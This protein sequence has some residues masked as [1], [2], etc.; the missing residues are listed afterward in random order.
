MIPITAP[1]GR[2]K[3][4]INHTRGSIAHA[5]ALYCLKGGTT[6][7]ICRPQEVERLAAEI[8]LWAQAMDERLKIVTL[9][10]LPGL[11]KD[12]AEMM[13]QRSDKVME[14]MGALGEL[15]TCLGQQRTHPC[16]SLAIIAD[17]EALTQ[18]MPQSVGGL[19][20][21]VGELIP[22]AALKEKLGMEL[23]YHHEALCESPGQF[24]LR[25]GIVDIYPP[26]ESAP[27]RL[28]FFGETIDQIKHFDPTTQRSLD[29]KLD[30]ISLSS[31]RTDSGEWKSGGFMG[32]L[33]EQ[34]NWIVVEPKE[35]EALHPEAFNI[36]E[37]ISPGAGH[38]A[39]FLNR[40]CDEW[41]GL[42]RL[43]AESGFFKD[44]PCREA[45]VDIPAK[46]RP[47]PAA[48]LVGEERT[49]AE[50]KMLAGFVERVAPMKARTFAFARGET[51]KEFQ[52]IL[53]PL[54]PRYIPGAIG[55]GFIFRGY[56]EGNN[57]HPLY[58][59]AL[60]EG[61][62]NNGAA[63]QTPM[64][65]KSLRTSP[66]QAN[67]MSQSMGGISQPLPFS[68]V[69]ALQAQSAVKLPEQPHCSKSTALDTGDDRDN[70]TLSPVLALSPGDLP[71][72]GSVYT[73]ARASRR[74][75]HRNAVNELLDF[76]QVAEGDYLV[77]LEHGI[78]RYRGMGKLDDGD[79]VLSLE[80]DE[81]LI[82]HLRFS[83]SHLIS[84]Y[85]GLTRKNPKLSRLGSQSWTKSKKEAQQATLD[86]AAELLRLHAVRQSQPGFAFPSDSDLT[87][88]FDATFPFKLT[89]DQAKAIEAT[90]ADMKA[91]KPMDRLVCGDVGYGKTEVALRA[92]MKA[93]E[94]GKQVCVLC[95]TTIL[96]QQH[97][98]TFRERMAGFGVSVECLNRFKSHSEQKKILLALK[99]G[100]LDIVVGT[101]RLISK[102]VVFRDLG[103]II[104]DEEHRFG[105]EQKEKLKRMRTSV[106][107]LSMSATPIPRTLQM[108]LGGARDLS[109]IETAPQ[110]RRPIETIVKTFDEKLLKEAIEYEVSRGGQVFYLHNRVRTIARVAMRLREL[111]PTLRVAVGHGRMPEDDLEQV[112]T[113]FVAGKYDLLVCTTIIESGL[114]I[115]NC[116]TLVIEGADQFGLSQLYQI[117]G[118]VGR[119]NRQAYAYLFL[120]RNKDS[121]DSARD[122]LEA[123]RVHNELGAGFKIAIRDLELRGSGNLLGPEQSGHVAGIGFGLYCELLRESV[124]RLKNASTGKPYIPKTTVHFDFPLE[125]KIPSS[126]LPEARLRLEISREMALCPDMKEFASLKESLKDRF[127][128]PP[129]GVRNLI[130]INELRLM[131]QEKGFSSLVTEGDRLKL[132]RPDGSFLKQGA[133]FPR[134]G[135][136]TPNQKV[137]W[138]EGFLKE[139]PD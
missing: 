75:A 23:G 22:L 83:E 76:S 97:F 12:E 30:A 2:S 19:A 4:E 74:V 52:K 98:N 58:P 94:G 103:L 41:L 124:T 92:A 108:A 138:I 116:N 127:G 73:I 18:P 27:V 40:P 139:I 91:P 122:R 114:D 35:L 90:F 84:R 64:D 107:V 42:S 111:F 69:P 53:K 123:L 61:D 72:Y 10:T 86:Y 62:F 26:N 135:G 126:W 70:I 119:F 59:P 20:L 112:M 25:G 31:A 118:R 109:I 78:C 89:P 95:P 77:H 132:Q 67:E 44:A 80:F 9:P 15:A 121:T 136:E 33:P 51:A 45:L 47:L 105:V 32:H 113:D 6:V 117:R 79:E 57:T 125:T 137:A 96:S 38:F 131:A 81:G 21:R 115:P 129:E 130:K 133:L 17:I 88:E 56:R 93:V 110:N 7:V 39:N 85:V 24:A 63:P 65:S 48:G 11:D 14:L 54:A 68:R 43:G 128:K 49:Q 13:L 134:I 50:M 1:A 60:R 55:E 120:H 36:P 34:S 29:D 5:A 101:H 106:D 28:D 37:K 100:A 99:N 87:R 66:E 82:M 8:E 71:P 46:Y 16:P 104:I 102:D 3:V